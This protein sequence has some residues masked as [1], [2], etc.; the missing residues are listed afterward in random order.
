MQNLHVPAIALSN[1]GIG[2]Q[3][4]DVGKEQRLDSMAVALIVEEDEWCF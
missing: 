3:K 4:P 1:V 2:I